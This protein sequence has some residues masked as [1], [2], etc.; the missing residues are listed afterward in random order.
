MTKTLALSPAPEH[1]SLNGLRVVCQLYNITPVFSEKVGREHEMSY[2]SFETTF[3][4]K[5]FTY[6]PT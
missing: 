3:S 4:Y 5:D 6:I 1:L 2:L